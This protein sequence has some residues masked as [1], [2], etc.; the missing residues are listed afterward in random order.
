MLYSSRPKFKVRIFTLVMRDLF[1]GINEIVDNNFMNSKASKLWLGKPNS[2]EV[3]LNAR[4][5]GDFEKL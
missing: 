1:N 4:M 2:R 3:I 5:I